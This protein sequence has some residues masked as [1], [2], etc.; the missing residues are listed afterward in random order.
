MFLPTLESV[1]Q[2]RDQAGIQTSPAPWSHSVSYHGLLRGPDSPS[3]CHVTVTRCSDA[4]IVLYSGLLKGPREEGPA[5]SSPELGFSLLPFPSALHT[6]A[7]V[8]LLKFTSDQVPSLK[9]LCGL[10]CVDMRVNWFLSRTQE[11]IP[12]SWRLPSCP[13]VPTSYTS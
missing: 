6:A 5:A 10:P 12:V 4:L 11:P 2:A 3:C 1:N 9:R 7:A 13:L 8:G